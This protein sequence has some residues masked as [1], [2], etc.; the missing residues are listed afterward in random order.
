MDGLAP[1]IGWLEQHGWLLVGISAGSLL[2]SLLLLPWFVARIPEDYFSHPHR[3]RLSAESSHPLLQLAI[4]GVKNLLGLLLVAAGI[5][6]LFTPGQ[7]LLTLLV[8]LMLMNFPGKYHLER[9]L[10]SRPGVLQAVNW[11]RRRGGHPPL[12]VERPDC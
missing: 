8:G 1:L 12:S 6:M 5:I 3:H 9:W 4:S 2:L 7:G 11:L 10:V